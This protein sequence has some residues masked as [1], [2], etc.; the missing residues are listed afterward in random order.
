VLDFVFRPL[1]SVLDVG[2]RVI[3]KPLQAPGHELTVIVDAIHRS[4]DSIEHHVEVIEGLATSVEPLKDS[5][6]NLNATM[7][8]L[9]TLM[10]PMASAESGM[11]DVQD[12]VH[13]V[14]HGVHRVE[15]FFGF[16]RHTAAGGSA[17][18]Q[19]HADAGDEQPDAPA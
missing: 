10:A 6:N 2:E 4:A 19:L 11:Q 8:D 12:G 5:V 7:V 14:E 3:S 1:R 9:V 18:K 17:T 16:R 15:R 13:D